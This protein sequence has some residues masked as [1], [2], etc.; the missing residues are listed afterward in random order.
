MVEKS[1]KKVSSETRSK[2]KSPQKNLRRPSKKTIVFDDSKH[3]QVDSSAFSAQDLV[4]CSMKGRPS[5]TPTR[6]PQ[7]IGKGMMMMMLICYRTRKTLKICMYLGL[8][9]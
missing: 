8:F 6:S 9:R 7:I 1:R 2:L 5:D 4:Y 3:T